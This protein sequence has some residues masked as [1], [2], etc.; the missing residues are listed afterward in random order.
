MSLFT[1][2][3]LA[4]TRSEDVAQLAGVSKG[5]LYRYYASKEELF[6]AVVRNSLGEVIAE[7]GE[8]VD[9]W[10]GN[11]GDLLKLLAHTWWIRIEESRASGIFKLIIAEVGNLPEL[12]Q[13]YV[14]EVIAPTHDL[15][16]R[17]IVRGM[18]R[19]EFRRLD[20][21]SVV[22]TLMASA[23]FLVLF[24]QCTAACLH[25]PVPLDPDH[26]MN[27]Q[28]DLLLLGLQVRAKAGATSPPQEAA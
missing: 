25:N 7:G 26:F 18:D 21:T 3:G 11:T 1:S 23:Q 5:T 10:D 8:L 24:P 15:L 13:F 6:K 9:H 4:A 17:A 27:T 20:V 28:I 12:A 16:S 2:K 22:H 14:D 19:G